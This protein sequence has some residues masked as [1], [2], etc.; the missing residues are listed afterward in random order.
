M[1][2]LS[3]QLKLK[4]QDLRKVSTRV[5]LPNGQVYYDGV[6]EESQSF[7][8][9]VDTKPDLQV[10]RV[11]QGIFVGS[12]DVANE[13]S[14]LAANKI[15]HVLNVGGFPSQKINGLTYLDVTILD[16][17]EE[18]LSHHFPA[19]FQFIESALLEDTGVLVHCN[20]GVSRSVS[21]VVAYLLKRRKW[22]LEKAF[23]AV[24]KVRPVA[25]PNEG[26][27]KQLKMYENDCIIE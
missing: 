26:F 1:A 17:P 6:A 5:T 20:A 14:L 15:T 12:Q 4:G 2:S 27:M 19:C 21:I 25:K 8:F 24:R 3:D 10:G 7:G 9:V 11:Q 16:L 18:P 13:P 22:S 23:T